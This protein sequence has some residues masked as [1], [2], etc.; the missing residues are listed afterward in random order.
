MKL[1][2]TKNLVK[3]YSA[4]WGLFNRAYLQVHAV[5]GVTISIEKG[6]TLGLVGESGCGKST[7][8]RLIA[9]LENPDAGNIFYENKDITNC[10]GAERRL[11]RKKIQII[12][13]DSYSSLDPRQTVGGIIMEPLANFGVGDRQQRKEMAAELLQKVGLEPLHISRYPHEFSGGQRQRINIARALALTPD[14]I[15]CDEPVSSLDVSIR[16]QILNLLKQLKDE[17]GLAYL[18]ISHDLAAVS[19][20]ADRIAVMYLGKIV[21]VLDADDFATHS[22]H[23]YSWALL[24][25][26]P[27]PDLH[28]KGQEKQIL[29]GEPPSGVN[30]P[31]GCRFHPRCQRATAICREQEPELKEVEKGHLISCHLAV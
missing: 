5:D 2:Q 4:G 10:S 28:R 17:F 13:Q 23:P 26:I 27:D 31:K 14:L 20:M 8:G 22:Y 11:L 7:L 1:L 25:A 15:I 24:D 18:F 29:Y 6:E 3:Y 16:A 21:E 19:Y 30:P 9:R 12:F